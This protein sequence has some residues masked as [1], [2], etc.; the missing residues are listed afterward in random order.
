VGVTVRNADGA[1]GAAHGG[2]KRVEITG[3]SSAGAIEAAIKSLR[4]ASL[5]SA[6]AHL[7]LEPPGSCWRLTEWGRMALLVDV[8][9]ARTVEAASVVVGALDDDGHVDAAF[10]AKLVNVARP[11]RVSWSR[12]A[13]EQCTTPPEDQIR[14]LGQLGVEAL[15]TSGS[16]HQHHLEPPHQAM[17]VWNSVGA[18]QFLNAL[19]REC[20]VL[21]VATCGV[22]VHNAGPLRSAGL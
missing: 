5:S 17:I 4:L 9:L 19:A 20:N 1:S 3:C 7:H 15:Y 21:L 13:F 11:M 22:N 10:V 18:L 6:K 14:L 8:A 12:A 16:Q 2:A